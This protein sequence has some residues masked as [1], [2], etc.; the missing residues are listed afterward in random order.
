[1]II[2]VDLDGVIADFRKGFIN[3]WKKKFPHEQLQKQ[4]SFYLADD[5]PPKLNKKIQSIYCAKNFFCN[6]PPVRGSKKALKEMGALGHDVRICTAFVSRN[7]YCFYEKQQ[8]IER[9]FGHEY[10]KKALFV[11]D[12]TFIKGDLLIDDKPEITGLHTPEWEHVIFDA[13][14]NRHIKNKKRITWKTWK[15]VLKK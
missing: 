4:R 3:A 14:Y 1:M 13:P 9:H 5:Y 2:L 12:K 11:K 7:T 6:L 15:N 10:V 8:W